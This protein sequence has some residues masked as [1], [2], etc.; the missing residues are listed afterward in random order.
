MP[1]GVS[2]DG[3][4]H[5]HRSNSRQLPG[6]MGFVVAGVMGTIHAG[7]S[8]YWAVGGTWLLWSL[9]SG[10]L[11][12]FKGREW[13]LIPVGVIKLVAAASP[14]VLSRWDWPARQLTRTA[15]WLGAVVLILWGGL[16]TVIGNLVLT[17]I[18]QPESGYD[19]PGMVGHAWLWEPLF[20]AWGIALVIGLAVTRK[21]DRSVRR[22]PRR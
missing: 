4:M 7:F 21:Q 22:T 6:I 14:L 20:L 2:D 11:E 15:C 3:G 8:L 17:G 9:G 19:R 5:R 12:T 16:N 13:V 10:L 18:I 1:L